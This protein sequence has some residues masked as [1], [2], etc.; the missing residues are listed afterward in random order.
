MNF[1]ELEGKNL[2]LWYKTMFKQNIICHRKSILSP[3]KTFQA[4]LQTP[5]KFQSDL[6]HQ[7]MQ[8]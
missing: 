3:D 5:E 7:K 4:I 2:R 6:M 8:Q 1:G